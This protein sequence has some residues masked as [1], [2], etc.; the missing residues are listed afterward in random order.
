MKTC[1]INYTQGTDRQCACVWWLQW[2]GRSKAQNKNR[3]WCRGAHQR[4]SI[5]S[6]TLTFLLL[7]RQLVRITVDLSPRFGWRAVVVVV[8]VCQTK[9]ERSPHKTEPWRANYLSCDQRPF[10]PPA[11]SFLQ[12]KSNRGV[13]KEGGRVSRVKGGWRNDTGRDGWKAVDKGREQS[14]WGDEEKLRVEG[15][16]G[17][18]DI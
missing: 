18:R 4:L 16:E 15:R 1:V 7:C 3:L 8:L 10:L 14:P 5:C 2:C 6:F 11:L 17:R 9:L 13:V 12:N